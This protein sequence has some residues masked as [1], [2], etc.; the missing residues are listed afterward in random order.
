MSNDTLGILLGIV[1]IGLAIGL[2]IIG[3]L[4]KQQFNKLST[5][6]DNKFNA[7]NT[8][9]DNR[10]NELN[11][12]INGVEMK[13]ENHLSQIDNNI[14]LLHKENDIN[15]N[16]LTKLIENGNENIVNRIDISN[17]I[18]AGKLLPTPQEKQKGRYADD[19]SS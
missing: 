19:E 7:L 16:T 15:I 2:T 6:I 1:G 17:L 9:I 5:Q 8:K 13:L 14:E 12:K 4:G 3:T 11:T 18:H 10:F